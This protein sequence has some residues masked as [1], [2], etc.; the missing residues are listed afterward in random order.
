M[1]GKTLEPFSVLQLDAETSKLPR[2]EK[3]W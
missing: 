2:G 1:K 3:Q